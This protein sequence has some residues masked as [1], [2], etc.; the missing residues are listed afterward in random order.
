MD[1]RY[2]T[3]VED[4][5]L[6]WEKVKFTKGIV[7]LL[8]PE[9]VAKAMKSNLSPAELN[10]LRNEVESAVRAAAFGV[11]PEFFGKINH[12]AQHSWNQQLRQHI[13][14]ELPPSS[15]KNKQQILGWYRKTAQA[16]KDKEGPTFFGLKNRA[17]A[18][19]FGL[20]PRILEAAELGV[21]APEDAKFWKDLIK[22]QQRL[23]K[24]SP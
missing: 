24:T 10:T 21:I 13:V 8:E 18:A 16:L 2:K 4:L 9:S 7:P 1:H 11:D 6:S 15:M 19:Q 20:P 12:A 23:K 17:E 22:T 5:G 3:L 14:K